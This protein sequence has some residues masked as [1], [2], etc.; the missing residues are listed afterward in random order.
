MSSNNYST[1]ACTSPF[2]QHTCRV[3]GHKRCHCARCASLNSEIRIVFSTRRR[4]DPSMQ[5]RKSL[6][7]PK[8][9]KCLQ[10][11]KP[12][13]FI[14]P[15][16]KER[17]TFIEYAGFKK[18]DDTT[19]TPRSPPRSPEEHDPFEGITISLLPPPL[20]TP[21]ILANKNRR[22]PDQDGPGGGASRIPI[23]GP[24]RSRM[25]SHPDQRLKTAL[26]R[27]RAAVRR[28]LSLLRSDVASHCTP[29]HNRA[30]ER[31]NLQA[32]F[33]Q[34][35]VLIRRLCPRLSS[36]IFSDDSGSQR[37]LMEAKQRVQDAWKVLCWAALGVG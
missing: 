21:T 30:P 25:R 31:H 6:A 35:A 13:Q 23:R 14:D 9:C 29:A 36:A 1:N 34:L 11:P 32:L 12:V 10:Q 24:T 16:E 8:C 20:P 27:A 15:I 3:C 4:R 33:A 7:R 28:I 26:R 5:W 37:E 2:C 19:P 22:G 17:L 18:E